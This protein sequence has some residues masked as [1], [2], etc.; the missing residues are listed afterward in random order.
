MGGRRNGRRVR[1]WGEYRFCESL[2]RAR[3]YARVGERK[4][5]KV[6][7]KTKSLKRGI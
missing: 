1:T 3:P 5:N 4:K 2:T 6:F 7:I